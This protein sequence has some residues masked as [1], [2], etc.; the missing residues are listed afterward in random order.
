MQIK[1]KY[2]HGQAL[3]VDR[4]NF[5]EMVTEEIKKFDNIEIIREEY[6][7]DLENEK[8]ITIIATGPLTSEKMVEQINKIINV[9]ATPVVARNYTID[10][11]L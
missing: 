10:F 9:G 3:A 6:T 7:K 8:G 11:F 2:Q 1:Q 4:E 5:S